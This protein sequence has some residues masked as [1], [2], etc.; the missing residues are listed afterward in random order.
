MRSNRIT[1]RKSEDGE[2]GFPVGS[3]LEKEGVQENERGWS[4]P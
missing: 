2:E 4:S 1:Y 3:T